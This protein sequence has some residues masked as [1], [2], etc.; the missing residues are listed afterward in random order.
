MILFFALSAEE[1]LMH[2]SVRRASGAFSIGGR[3]HPLLFSKVSWKD[4]VLLC[5]RDD[6]DFRLDKYNY[7]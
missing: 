4:E 5:V 3:S 7:F 1:V 6:I 2:R